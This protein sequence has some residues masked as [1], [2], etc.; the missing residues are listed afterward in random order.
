M[1]PKLT[2][3]AACRVARYDRATLNEDIS[4]GRFKCA[5]ETIPGR[6]RLFDPDDMIALFLY[7]E[8]ID[9]GFTKDRAGR[10]SCSVASCAREYPEAT[11]ITYVEDYF[12]GSGSAFPADRVP[13]HNSW[14]EVSFN[15]TDIRRATTFRIGKLRQMIAHY[16]E[17]ERSIIGE[18]D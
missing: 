13:A 11:A 7:R 1:K 8:M 15:G 3:K 14:D 6:A 5:P 4:L 18:D 9:D 2:T 16:T 17:E 12:V 10:V